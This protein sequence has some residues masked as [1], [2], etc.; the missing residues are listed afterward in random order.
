[1]LALVARAILSRKPLQGR[2][3][4]RAVGTTETVERLRAEVRLAADR[5]TD[6]QEMLVELVDLANE[7]LITKDQATREATL[8]SCHGLVSRYLGAFPLESARVLLDF[9]DAGNVSIRTGLP[10]GMERRGPRW[11]TTWPDG[12]IL[13]FDAVVCAAGFQK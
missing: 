13:E 1:I 7:V 3:K 4:A 8:E 2:S 10:I 11:H 5:Q 9:I 6:W 12:R